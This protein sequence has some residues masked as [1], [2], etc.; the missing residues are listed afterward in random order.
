M[1]TKITNSGIEA[2]TLP[3]P[4]RGILRGKQSV[5]VE[6]APALV[7]S[8]LGG[9]ERMGGLQVSE[10]IG[11]TDVYASGTFQQ[12]VSGF[13]PLSVPEIAGA[14]S[15]WSPTRGL[16]GVGAGAVTIADQCPNPLNLV[17]DLANGVP[18]LLPL[19]APPAFVGTIGFTQGVGAWN[20]TPAA[21]LKATT[22]L[23]A[24]AWL[25]IFDYVGTILPVIAQYNTSGG[26]G[27]GN[28]QFILYASS[29]GGGQLLWRIRAQ[30]DSANIVLAVTNPVRLGTP[31]FVEGVYKNQQL[32]LWS[33]RVL[34]GTLTGPAALPDLS[35][36]TSIFSSA[37]KGLQFPGATS[38][39]V[40]ATR[41]PSD[42]NRDLLY[43]FEPLTF[44]KRRRL[45]TVVPPVL[46]GG[47]L[48]ATSVAVSNLSAPILVEG[49]E[50]HA[51]PVVATSGGGAFLGVRVTTLNTLDFLFLGP[52]T[53]VGMGFVLEY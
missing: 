22:E 24:A 12:A 44:T 1:P 41:V 46:G 14:G 8:A 23:Y 5:V 28:K 17:T 36:P 33:N 6:G 49:T 34:I 11:P 45:V 19:G 4:F 40:L 2:I 35:V 7:L 20:P 25:N 16:T 48:G 30:D 29:A 9:P 52:T 18:T 51:K 27:S 37:D 15:W 43:A 50:V 21:K 26:A 38:N 13:T 39:L 42:T 32:E 10:A 3:A 31:Q 53:A 47:A